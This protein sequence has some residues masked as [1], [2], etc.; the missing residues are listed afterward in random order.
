MPK[1]TVSI[2]NYNAGDYLLRCVESLEKLE[3]EVSIEV[4][5]VDNAS[6]DDSISKLKVRSSKFKIKLH[7]ILNDQNLG[8]GKAHNQVLKNL[9]TE[10]AL[11]LNPDVE[12]VKGN[13]AGPISIMDANSEVGAVT[14]KIILSNGQ[15]DLTA[16]RGFPT[17]WAS[18]K[19]YFL[20]DDSDYHLLKKNM[21]QIHEVDAIS[22]AF[23]LTRKKILDQVGFFDEDYFMYAEDIDLCYRIKQ[24]GYKIMY[25]P[26]V[27]ILHHKGISSGLKKHSQDATTATLATKKRSLDAFYETMKIFYKK[28][29]AKNYPTPVNWLVY[30]GI[31]LKWYLAK[32][33]LVA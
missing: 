28:H 20:K 24:A 23:F 25:L 4:Y 3:N 16:H 13:L 6:N 29:F 1:L 15:V 33:K 17:P 30:L 27:K 5:I 10:Y 7:F 31:N 22:G 26:S 32:R 8:F 12:L 14:G 2:V 9:K 21:H 19:Y 18:F 11:I